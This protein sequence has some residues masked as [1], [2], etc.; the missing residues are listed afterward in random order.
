MGMLTRGTCTVPSRKW[1][2][3]FD[4]RIPD[5]AELNPLYS[6]YIFVN[7]DNSR[8]WVSQRASAEIVR[9]F[10]LLIEVLILDS[11]DGLVCEP[12]S[13]LP[14]NAYLDSQLSALK[15]LLKIKPSEHG[16][17]MKRLGN[18]LGGTRSVA[19]SVFMETAATA[20]LYSK[21]VALVIN[22]I[23]NN[24][25]AKE[26]HNNLHPKDV[27]G[28]GEVISLIREALRKEARIS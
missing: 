13:W 9:R 7:I 5:H 14:V 20:P 17:L 25:R 16:S 4:S 22:Y 26:V 23:F 18:V 21:A 27:K 12:S 15:R 24:S 1:L 8:D 19:T 6:R 3:A 2:S 10:S 28:D 11:A